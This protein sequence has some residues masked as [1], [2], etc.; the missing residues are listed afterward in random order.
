MKFEGIY[1]PAV[2]PFRPGGEIDRAE[3]ANV[4]ESLVA[5]GVH[6]IV[7]GGST[8]EYYAQTAEERFTLAAFAKEVETEWQSIKNG[9]LALEPAMVADIAS[10]FRYPDYEKLNDSSRELLAARRSESALD[11]RL[12]RSHTA[13][14]APASAAAS[15]LRH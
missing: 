5:A 15:C 10:R 11:C 12:C 4:L 13:L 8:G 7:V 1:T 3:F 14:T 2:T 9:A 6:G